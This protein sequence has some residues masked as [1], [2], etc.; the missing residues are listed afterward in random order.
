MAEGNEICINEICTKDPPC[1]FCRFCIH[2]GEAH[3]ENKNSWKKHFGEYFNNSHFWR[4]SFKQESK[5]MKKMS[6]VQ[7]MRG[8]CSST[9]YCL[10]CGICIGCGEEYYEKSLW[11]K[12][13]RYFN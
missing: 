1:K 2:C 6:W 10:F 7:S 3:E 5:M 9:S 12:W 13:G 11:R 4:K 8:R